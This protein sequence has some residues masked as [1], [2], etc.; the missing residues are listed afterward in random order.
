[1]APVILILIILYEIL[2]LSEV[3][4]I[5]MPHAQLLGNIYYHECYHE[6]ES[7]P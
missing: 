4:A 6:Q 3:A 1:M 2:E 5:F 7:L